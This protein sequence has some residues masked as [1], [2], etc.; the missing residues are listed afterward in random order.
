MAHVEKSDTLDGAEKALK[1]HEDFVS[2][3]GANEEKIDGTV[4]TGQRLLDAK[5]LYTGKVQDKMSSIRDRSGGQNTQGGLLF[6]RNRFRFLSK[7]A[8]RPSG[9]R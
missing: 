8:F 2:T 7:D 4:Q 9:S 1:K 5:N 6:S 3:M